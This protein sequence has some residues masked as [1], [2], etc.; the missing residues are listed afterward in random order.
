[1]KFGS[2]EVYVA[3]EVVFKYPETVLVADDPPAVCA[4]RGQR[5]DR[6]V[7]CAE[8]MVT[9]NVPVGETLIED[10][11]ESPRP[12][13]DVRQSLERPQDRADIARTSGTALR[14]TIERLG[15]PL[16]VNANP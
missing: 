10:L 2:F 4:V 15:M 1:M 9:L 5:I 11:D 7:D 16:E 3:T 6:P 14:A 12:S 8:V 13:R